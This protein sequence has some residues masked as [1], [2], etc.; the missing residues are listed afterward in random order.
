[1]VLLELTADSFWTT[2]KIDYSRLTAERDGKGKIH[3]GPATKCVEISSFF[4]SCSGIWDFQ[5]L[6]LRRREEGSQPAKMTREP[7]DG[8]RKYH[9][10]SLQKMDF[11]SSGKEHSE[12]VEPLARS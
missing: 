11:Q 4:V 7:V 8:K 9:R 1:M 5:I 6:L 2:L 10:I 3:F 12:I